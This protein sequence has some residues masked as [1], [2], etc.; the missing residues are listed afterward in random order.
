MKPALPVGHPHHFRPSRLPA[1]GDG[2]ARQRLRRQGCAARTVRRRDPPSRGRERVID[3]AL[4][5][6][7]RTTGACPLSARERDVLVAARPG[8][9]V[10]EIAGKLFLS[11]GTVRNYLSAA[12]AK[13]GTRN[14]AEAVRM[15]EEQG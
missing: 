9:T 10:S 13:T 12:I 1:P 15:A 14:R 11:E 8:A 4:A 6:Q 3:P 7:S 2:V 5:A